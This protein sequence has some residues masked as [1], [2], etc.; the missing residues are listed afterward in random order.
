[1]SLKMPVTIRWSD[2]D[3]NAHVRHSVYYDWGAAS[4]IHFFYQNG[5]DAHYMASKNLGPILFREEAI[6]RREVRF[7]QQY[8]I[9]LEITAL[10]PDFSR[11]SFRH[12][13]LREDDT[14]CATIHVDGAWIDTQL[15]KLTIP[16][17]EVAAL[18]NK[19]PHAA[20]FSWI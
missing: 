6:F 11:F 20:D 5:I 13:I 10:K 18:Q 15:R 7:G 14:L 3:P 17:A 8:F 4:R 1:M 9:D 2:L 12:T 19:A 16:P